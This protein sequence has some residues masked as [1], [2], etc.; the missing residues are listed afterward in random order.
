MDR[1]RLAIVALLL[2]AALSSG[3]IGNSS[4]GDDQVVASENTGPGDVA[5]PDGRIA[6][7]AKDGAWL[8][9]INSP[10]YT[11]DFIG[12]GHLGFQVPANTTGVVLEIHWTPTTPLSDELYVS[13]T[14]A[15]QRLAEAVGPSPLRFELPPDDLVKGEGVVARVFAAGGPAGAYVDQAH[16]VHT[17]FFVD[18][19]FTPATVGAQG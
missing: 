5:D 4:P 12:T 17:W 18:R 9:S 16:T 1:S 8:L 19:A 14:H 2:V 3:C 15:E 7:A 13:I 11:S 6:H 10:A